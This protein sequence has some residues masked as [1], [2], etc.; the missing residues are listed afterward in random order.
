MKS[1][2]L[3]ARPQTEMGAEA[4]YRRPEGPHVEFPIV[5]VCHYMDAA[6]VPCD[7]CDRASNKNIRKEDGLACHSCC[8]S[9]SQRACELCSSCR[10]YVI[11][12]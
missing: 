10:K 8:G 9:W 11:T 7:G 1:N 6:L 2:C 12:A 4:V 3:K 5:T